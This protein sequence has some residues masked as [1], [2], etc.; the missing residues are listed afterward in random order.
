MKNFSARR[1]AL[2]IR[3][4]IVSASS[5]DAILTELFI[6]PVCRFRL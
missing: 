4:V 3:I 1:K 6:V 2:L 5:S